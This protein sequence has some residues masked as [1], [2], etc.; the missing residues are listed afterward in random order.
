[1][2]AV[3]RDLA[4]AAEPLCAE[5]VTPVGIIIDLIAIHDDPTDICD[6]LRATPSAASIPVLFLGTGEEAVRSTTDALIAG[7]DG[8]FQLPVEASR[9]TAKILAYTGTPTPDL[10]QGL[11]VTAAEEEALLLWP[12]IQ[13]FAKVNRRQPDVRSDDPTEKRYAEALL[14]LR[15]KKREHDAQH[16]SQGS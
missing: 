12:K 7:G 3:A 4:A 11:L 16:R 6:A 9:V 5:G 10:P 15:K 1:M 8:Y 13:Q 2:V 14:F